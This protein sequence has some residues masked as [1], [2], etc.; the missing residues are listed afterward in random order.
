[1]MKRQE[2]IDMIYIPAPMA[3]PKHAVIQIPAAVVRPR[4][5]PFIWIM[6]P[7]PRKPIPEITCAA[8]RPGSPFFRPIYSCG[9]YMEIIIA[10]VAPIAMRANVRIPAA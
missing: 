2:K 6:A 4:T 8:I 5:E 1:M 3:R 10:R 7:A 9:M